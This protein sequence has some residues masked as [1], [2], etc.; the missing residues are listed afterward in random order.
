MRKFVKLLGPFIAKFWDILMDKYVKFAK[1]K[2]NL[3]KLDQYFIKMLVIKE[4]FKV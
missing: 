4:K 2:L 3:Y 1:F